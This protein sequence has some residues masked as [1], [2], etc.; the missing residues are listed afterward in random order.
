MEGNLNIRPKIVINLNDRSKKDVTSDFENNLQKL[1]Y[2]YYNRYLI[3]GYPNDTKNVLSENGYG[4]DDY[5]ET[6]KKL[7]LVIGAASNSGKMSTC[8]G[9]I[10]QDQQNNIKSG[11]A[12][13]ETFPIWSLPISHPVNLAYEAATADIGDFNVI[14]TYHEVAYGKRSVNYNRDFEAF[15]IIKMLSDK[16]LNKDNPITEYKSPTDMGINFAGYA[17]T[18]DEIVCIASLNE[19]RRRRDWYNE[20][21]ARG[22]VD[23]NKSVKKCESLEL[24]ALK[25]IK[26]QGYNL[27]L[28]I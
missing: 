20:I 8:L 9:Q 4:F 1:G 27:D 18:D 21:L 22:G 7:I 26:E 12:K 13:Y 5:I 19:I 16:F 3:E 28:E 25:Y 6:S 11:Y 17:I 15:E 14:D 23:K 2:N 10:F 24:Q